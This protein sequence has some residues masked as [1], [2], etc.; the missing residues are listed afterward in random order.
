MNFTWADLSSLIT[1]A[2]VEVGPLAEAKRILINR[3]IGDLPGLS[4]DAER[5]LQVLRNLIGNALKFTPRGGTVSI[6]ARHEKKTVLVSVADT[7]PGIPAEH[8]AVIFDKFRQAPG[9]GRIPGSGL[10]LAIVKHIIEAHGGTVWVQS[11]AGNGSVF[12]FQ[13]PA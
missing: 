4:I 10:G 5:M 1:R 13:L 7:G 3:D 12:T 8:V 6:T 9:A 11:K 2:V